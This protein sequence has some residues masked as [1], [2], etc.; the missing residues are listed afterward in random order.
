MLRSLLLI[1]DNEDDVFFFQVAMRKLAL[2]H[3]LVVAR[4]GREGL[5]RLQ[6]SVSASPEVG[7]FGLVLLD[8]KLPFLDGFEVLAGLHS[9]PSGCCPPVVVLTTSE[10][11]SD[12]QLAWRLG[13]SAVLVK[14]NRPEQ[15]VELLRLLGAKWLSDITVATVPAGPPLRP[16]GVVK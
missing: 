4:D 6:E 1:E 3:P 12:V 16:A 13:A 2:P 15:L 10:K 5:R 9:L 11:Q 14:P 7:P 8:L